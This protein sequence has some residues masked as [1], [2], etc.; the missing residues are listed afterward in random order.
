MVT[1]CDGG[2]CL[3]VGFSLFAGAS[4]GPASGSQP[5]S[6]EVPDGHHDPVRRPRPR[7][8]GVHQHRAA[9]VSR[10]PGRVQRPDPAGLRAGPAP[11]RQLVPA[12]PAAA[13]SV[14][15]AP[16]SSASP[17]TW[18][19]AAGPGPPSPAACAPSPGST[20]TPSRKNCSITRPPRTSAGPGWTTS[21]TR[22]GW[23]ATNSARCWSPPGS[24]RR[25]STR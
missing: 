4:A 25:P 24:A 10:I 22:P 1:W 7:H 3:T 21:P 6:P 9:G 19:P 13:C 12:A 16:T 15:A 11:V 23:T 8:A 17:A 20:G 18:K 2:G 14:P 5:E